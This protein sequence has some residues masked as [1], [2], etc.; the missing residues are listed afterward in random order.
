M[1]E[2]TVPLLGIRPTEILAQMRQNTRVRIVTEAGLVTAKDSNPP[3][4]LPKGN[5]YI[6]DGTSM[7]RKTVQ[8]K[9]RNGAIT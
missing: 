1:S 5:G 7:Q 6:N 9:E 4:S 3:K 8:Q 2:P